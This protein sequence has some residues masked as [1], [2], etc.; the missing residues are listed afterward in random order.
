MAGSIS[1][2]IA[3]YFNYLPESSLNFVDVG[4]YSGSWKN[5]NKDVC[6]KPGYWVGVEPNPYMGYAKHMF[7]LFFNVALDNVEQPSKMKFNVNG[8]AMCSSLLR[9]KSELI[10]HNFAER[11]DK[12][13]VARDIDLV[14]EQVEVDVWSFKHL[15]DQVPRFQNENIHFIKIDTQGVDIRVVESMKEY[16]N[17]TYFIMIESVT[18]ENKDVVLYEGQTT[19][20]EDIERMEKIGFKPF[21]VYDYSSH[22]SPEADIIFANTNLVKP[23]AR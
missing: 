19:I 11:N 18:S 12:W 5:E 16:L 13:F 7:D 22:A 15:L 1:P 20:K 6:K 10:T 9:M 3:E 17:K 14:L 21:K 8:D 4:A 23:I 2:D